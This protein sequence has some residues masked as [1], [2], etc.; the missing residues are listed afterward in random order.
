M[1]TSALSALLL[2]FVFSSQAQNNNSKTGKITGRIIDSLSSRPIEYATIG[3][4]TQSENKVVNGT[5]TDSSGFFNLT[6]VSEG[7]YKILIEFIGYKKGE[8]NNKL[9]VGSLYLQRVRQSK[10]KVP[11]SR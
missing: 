2:L 10:L 11:S 6:N 5:T 9:L 3:L 8:K 1:K 7:T 4:F